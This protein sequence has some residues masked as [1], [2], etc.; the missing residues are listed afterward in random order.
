MG[1]SEA[2][3]HLDRQVTERESDAVLS[4]SFACG[5]ATKTVY[6]WSS[7]IMTNRVSSFFCVTALLCCA[8]PQA[9]ADQTVLRIEEDWELHIQ[10]PDEHLNAPQVTTTMKPFGS[11]SDVFFQVHLNHASVP[12]YAAGGLQVAAFNDADCVDQQ[13]ILDGVKLNQQSEQVRWTQVLIQDE[14]GIHFG[15][16]TG[17]GASWGH[18]GGAATFVHMSSSAGTLANYSIQ[19]SA[20]NSGV[21][22]AGNRVE[23]LRLTKVRFFFAS[24][25]VVETSVN[26]DAN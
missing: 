3:P 17:S 9:W 14:Q 15:V 20:E 1:P 8:Q 26:L 24:G 21:T 23:R 11:A 12:T 13:R 5:L 19:Q 16:V 2:S 4:C 7:R 6:N 18:F 22:Y 25:D 10:T